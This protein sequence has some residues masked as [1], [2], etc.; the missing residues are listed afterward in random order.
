M[1]W[2][3]R[4]EM[5]AEDAGR[6]RILDSYDWHQRLW[7]CF[8]GLPEEQRSFLTRV[9]L[10]EGAVRA[11]LLSERKPSRPAWCPEAAFALR[12]IASG[13]LT[14]RHYA[15]DL[16]VNPTKALVQRNQDGTPKL[17]ANG[18]R[19]SGKRVPLVDPKELRAWI[20][21]KGIECGFR[22]A[23]A[24]PLEIG[25]VV[26]YHFRKKDHT[27]VHGGVQFRGILEA[28]D[29]AQFAQSYAKGIGT[30]KA[31]GFGLLLLSPV[32]L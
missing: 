23:K 29:S 32:Q 14:H 30:A 31:F 19:T 28:T 27:G 24:K 18:K 21:R 1:S 13:F 25:P 17:K 7:E 9:D 5:D 10:L 3:L 22:I 4:I 6:L 15:F 8:P 16:R 12:E 20:D 26:G 11:W 2:L